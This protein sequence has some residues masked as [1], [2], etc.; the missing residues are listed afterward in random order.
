[1]E[2]R[3]V[4]RFVRVSPLKTDRV[5]RLIR[6]QQVDK[7]QE[8]LAFSKRPIAIKIGKILT[9]A[10]ANATTTHE[11]IAVD[12]LYVKEAIADPGPTMKRIRPRAQGRANRILKRMTHIRIV[13]E[14][15]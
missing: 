9:S 10:V 13:V 5:L 3:A 12:R 8:I 1:M 15:R 6:G 2:A 14:E 11:E 4:A 7:A